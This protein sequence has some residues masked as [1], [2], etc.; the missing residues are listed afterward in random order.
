[1]VLAG[2]DAYGSAPSRARSTSILD[3]FW[4]VRAASGG[5]VTGFEVRSSHF[6]LPAAR[7]FLATTI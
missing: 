4:L 3:A 6:S 5:L 1:M 7:F 2:I